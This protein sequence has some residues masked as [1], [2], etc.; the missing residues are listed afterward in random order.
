MMTVLPA[1]ADIDAVLADADLQPSAALMPVAMMMVIAMM[2]AIAM[3]AVP[4]FR[5][6]GIH[7]DGKHSRKR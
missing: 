2:G 6:G 1:L 7:A 4:G 5:R 3:I